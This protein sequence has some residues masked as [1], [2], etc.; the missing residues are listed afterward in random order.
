MALYHLSTIRKR[1]KEIGLVVKTNKNM[2][3]LIDNNGEVLVSD[4]SLDQ[5]ESLL[6]GEYEAITG[7]KY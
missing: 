5:A 7:K 1:A 3:S 4:A 6:I 2:V